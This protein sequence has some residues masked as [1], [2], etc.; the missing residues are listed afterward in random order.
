MPVFVINGDTGFKLQE[1]ARRDGLDLF[2]DERIQLIDAVH[3]ARNAQTERLWGDWPPCLEGNKNNL[4]AEIDR[5][6]TAARRQPDQNHVVLFVLDEF[7]PD[8]A[9]LVNREIL[10]DIARKAY[11]RDRKGLGIETGVSHPNVWVV[12]FVRPTGDPEEAA[13]RAKHDKAKETGHGLVNNVF[14]STFRGGEAE[15]SN[16]DFVTIRILSELLL[17]PEEGKRIL[18]TGL[19]NAYEVTCVLGPAALPAGGASLYLARALK[20]TLDRLESREGSSAG[21]T[22]IGQP[23]QRLRTLVL[24]LVAMAKDRIGTP[25]TIDTTTADQQTVEMAAGDGPATASADTRTPMA[26]ETL[27]TISETFVRGIRWRPPDGFQLLR[28]D[29]REYIER[30]RNEFD[31]RRKTWSR[32]RP[33]WLTSFAGIN[34]DISRTIE[35]LSKAAIGFRGNDVATLEDLVADVQREREALRADARRCHVLGDTAERDERDT[36]QH[37]AALDAALGAFEFELDQLPQRRTILFFFLLSLLA[38]ILPFA[39]LLLFASDAYRPLHSLLAATL[40]TAVIIAVTAALSRR[41]NKLRQAAATL[42]G[43][44]DTW[45]RS[46]LRAFNNALRYQ[47]LTLGVGWLG[48][49]TEKLEKIER[50]LEER[51]NALDDCREMLGSTASKVHGVSIHE[52]RQESSLITDSV[53]R[54]TNVDWTQW[55]VG[56]LAESRSTEHAA[57]ATVILSDDGE[58]RRLLVPG[59]SESVA[60]RIMT[61]GEWSRLQGTLPHGVVPESASGA[62]STSNARI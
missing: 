45:R 7:V 14:V 4:R 54:L 20:G 25:S 57:E 47:V 24:E 58:E 52:N 39:A 8:R 1:I 36:Q 60:I 34:V 2:K 51:G 46:A 6:L 37:V 35:D 49:I 23:A 10:E 32:E 27:K 22:A 62:L 31:E 41:R 43:A 48:S 21:S 44:L 61:P 33:Q 11:A 56:F 26:P 28:R 55:V 29:L 30:E 17:H 59:L 13:E 5:I 50:S 3:V 15:R 40:A 42:R 9:P 53:Q 38:A 12:M 19:Q 16:S 18:Q